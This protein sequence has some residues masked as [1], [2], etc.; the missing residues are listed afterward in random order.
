MQPHYV[1]LIQDE[2]VNI[3]SIFLGIMAKLRD[4]WVDA[5]ET[6]HITDQNQLQNQL[7]RSDVWIVARVQ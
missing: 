1:I 4:T 3:G 7:I 5:E 6:E 2:R